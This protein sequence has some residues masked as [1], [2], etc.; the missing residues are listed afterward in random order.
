VATRRLDAISVLLTGDV[1]HDDLG[2]ASDDFFRR[3]RRIGSRLGRSARILDHDGGSLGVCMLGHHHPAALAADD[4]H[5]RHE[6]QHRRE[7]DP[8]D[9]ATHLG[10][11]AAPPGLLSPVLMIMNTVPNATITKIVTQMRIGLGF[12]SMLG[13]NLAAIGGESI[14]ATRKLKTLVLTPSALRA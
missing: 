4:D 2:A 14:R 13:S 3:R 10:A 8:P 9:H 11:V 7:S 1:S 12:S 6:Q 5:A